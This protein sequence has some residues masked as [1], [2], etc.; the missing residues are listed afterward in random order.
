MYVL[1]RSQKLRIRKEC[2]HR[3]LIRALLLMETWIIWWHF[4]DAC[5]RARVKVELNSLVWKV[6][7]ALA[8][9]PKVLLG[10][11]ETGFQ[12]MFCENSGDVP[13]RMYK[14]KDKQKVRR[15]TRI[16]TVPVKLIFWDKET[17]FEEN[18]S[19]S[20][21]TVPLR[22]WF[23]HINEAVARFFQPLGWF[24]DWST[25][26]GTGTYWNSLASQ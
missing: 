20:Y 26:W 10:Q 12:R 13:V 21:F 19:K 1:Q 16:G 8:A 18:L 24:H 15:K 5:L 9:V 2:S 7:V 11:Q 14:Y 22:P 4:A 23:S 6:V 3:Y 25:L 17:M